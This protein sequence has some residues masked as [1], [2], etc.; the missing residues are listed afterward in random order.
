MSLYRAPVCLACARMV[1]D[2]VSLSPVEDVLSTRRRKLLLEEWNH[3]LVASKHDVLNPLLAHHPI[4]NFEYLFSMVLVIVLQMPLI[5]CLRPAGR[6]STANFRA[7]DPVF[8]DGASQT[9]HEQ[10][11]GVSVRDDRRVARELFGD[12]GQRVEMRLVIDVD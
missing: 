7:L 4:N 8:G 9:E 5:A 6:L 12:E 1:S 11:S 3:H 10:A 2:I